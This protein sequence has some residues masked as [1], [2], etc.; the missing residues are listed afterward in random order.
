MLKR[1]FLKELGVDIFGPLSNLGKKLDAY[2]F[3]YECET[4][5]VKN[6]GGPVEVCF[7]R[8]TDVANVVQQTYMQL[9]ESGLSCW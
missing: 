6:A 7:L 3:K 5:T 1:L 9:L 2:K 8:V 4:A